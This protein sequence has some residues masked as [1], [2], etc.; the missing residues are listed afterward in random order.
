MSELPVAPELVERWRAGVAELRAASTC[1][2]CTDAA[3][4]AGPDALSLLWALET[5][6]GCPDQSPRARA[7]ALDA[8]GRVLGSPH[9]RFARSRRS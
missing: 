5:A 2:F 3:R 4:R 1:P 9:V 7:G 8:L 6:S